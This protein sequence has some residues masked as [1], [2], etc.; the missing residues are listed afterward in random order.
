MI[1]VANQNLNGARAHVAAHACI[2][3]LY[4]DH[5]FFLLSIKI[6]NWGVCFSCELFDKYCAKLLGLLEVLFN[7]YYKAL[8]EKKELHNE[9]RAKTK[10]KNKSCLVRR[11]LRSCSKID[12]A[13]TST[14]G[15]LR[16]SN[17]TFKTHRSSSHRRNL[18]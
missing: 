2:N 6:W 10:E 13:S 8:F 17:C 18:A 1:S 11:F 15:F 5:C 7:N 12:T 14:V 9:R 4:I 16:S 3:L